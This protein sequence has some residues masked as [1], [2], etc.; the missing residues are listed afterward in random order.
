MDVVLVCH[1][2]EH[3]IDVYNGILKAVQNGTISEEGLNDSVRRILKT[4]L[5]NLI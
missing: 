3:E 2:Y 4:K 5:M 1:E